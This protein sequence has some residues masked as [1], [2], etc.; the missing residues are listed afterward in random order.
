LLLTGRGLIVRILG[1]VGT[2]VLAHLLAV[3]DFGAVALGFTLL[4]L[5][6]FLADAGIGASLIQ[7]EEEPSRADLS[8]LMGF[9][10]AVTAAFV[11]AVAG[12]ASLAGK[13]LWVAALMLLSSPIQSWRA[14]AVLSLERNI[15][16]G[17]IAVVEIAEIVIYQLWALSAVAAGAGVWGLASAVIAKAV[18]GTGIVLWKFPESR[19]APTLSLTRVKRIL[20][21]GLKFQAAPAIEIVRYNLFTALLIAVGGYTALGVW[22]LTL[23][24]LQPIGLFL[25]SL[26]RVAFTAMARLSS[27]DSA[28]G[29][30]VRSAVEVVALPVALALTVLAA[31]SSRAADLVLGAKWHEAGS[32]VPGACAGL[33]LSAPLAV[34]VVSYLYANDDARVVLTS[35]STS[36]VV[37]LI[38]AGT[39]VWMLGVRGL[40]LAFAPPAICELLLLDRAVRRHS[41]AS[42]IPAVLLPAAIGGAAAGC[43]YLVSCAISSG[44]PAIVAS[45]ATSVTC[46]AGL[47]WLLVPSAVQTTRRALRLA[48]A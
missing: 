39:C 10:L 35:V 6:S 41:S 28:S 8:A 7:A 22:S 4:S 13:E 18:G 32:L 46:F 14:P 23:R 42:T 5:S 11:V 38:S 19:L 44:L 9:Q 1:F 40:A 47:A 12:V 31:V 2:V 26:S 33:A 16:Y 27:A 21:F 15:S 29:P 3:A 37:G 24:L 17:A 25:D 48:L 30:V 34:I 45:M 36:A 20:P 43:G